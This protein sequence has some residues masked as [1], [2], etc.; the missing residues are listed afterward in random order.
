M[1]AIPS[2]HRSLALLAAIVLA[3][4]LLLAVQ[5]KSDRQVRLVR[6]WAVAMVSPLQRAGAWTIDHIRS[7]WSNYVDLRHTR[8]ENQELRGEVERLLRRNGELEGRA[9]EADRLAELFGFRQAY[10]EVPMLAARVIGASAD[11][12]SRTI[13]INRGEKDGV[14]KNMG[15]ITPEGVVGKVLEAF[16]SNAQ[17]LLLNDKESGV[18][19]LLATT[20]TQGTVDG[21]GEPLLVMKYVRADEQVSA[22]E[23]VLTSGLDRIFPKDLP[24][25]TVSKVSPGNPFKD[26]DIRIKPAARLDRLEEVFVLLTLQE[27]DPRK[28][29]PQ[30]ISA[31]PAKSAAAPQ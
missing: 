23:R 26:K 30:S 3:Q 18:G 21:T 20:R 10:P 6:V 29:A 12:V 5:I 25:G 8:R 11:S 31:A 2:R 27:L 15:V 7:T 16:P 9:A 24:V 1:I 14:R 13:Y 4:V 22:G 17:V 19:A 28:E